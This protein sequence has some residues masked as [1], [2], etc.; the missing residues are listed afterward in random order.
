MNADEILASKTIDQ[1]NAAIKNGL[2]LLNFYDAMQ[3]QDDRII[4]DSIGTH[5]HPSQDYEVWTVR[6]TNER[7]RLVRIGI[8]DCLMELDRRAARPPHRSQS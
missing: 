6:D 2:E 8:S 5:E 7:K 1:L 4:R 3:E